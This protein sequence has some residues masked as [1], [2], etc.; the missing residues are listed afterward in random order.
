MS[1]VNVRRRLVVDTVIAC[2][3]AFAAARVVDLADLPTAI[4][5]VVAV[6]G[7]GFIVHD[8]F[9]TGYEGRPLWRWKWLDEGGPPPP[10]PG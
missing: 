4:S 3:V 2:V 9:Q 6:A 8:L 5:L 7:G 1:C 10:E